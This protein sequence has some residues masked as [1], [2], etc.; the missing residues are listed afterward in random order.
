[1]R[2]LF[3]N[4]EEAELLYQTAK[5]AFKDKTK[6]KTYT[7]MCRL[8][9]QKPKTTTS[10]KEKHFKQWKTAF[11]FK[12]N[13]NGFYGIKVLSEAEH[14][15]KILDLILADNKYYTLCL[16][17]DAYKSFTN[18]PVL[19]ITNKKLN[20]LLGYVNQ[21][22]FDYYPNYDN[23]EAKTGMQKLEQDIVATGS[24]RYPEIKRAKIEIRE[25]RQKQ[26][27]KQLK[28]SDT[29]Q[30]IDDRESQKSYDRFLEMSKAYK[31]NDASK[32][33]P[34][35]NIRRGYKDF[36]DHTAPSLNYNINSL[37]Q[38]LERYGYIGLTPVYIGVILNENGTAEKFRLCD[39]EADKYVEL[40]N[41]VAN[42]T[43]FG[44]Y[45]RVV[46]SKNYGAFNEKFYPALKEE[47]G[48]DFIYKSNRIYISEEAF[49]SN[50]EEKENLFQKDINATNLKNMLQF[51][52]K[53]FREKM[54]KNNRNRTNNE[55]NRYLFKLM[56]MEFFE[57]DESLY[58]I[59]EKFVD[60]SNIL[61]P[62]VIEWKKAFQAEKVIED[63]SKTYSI[64][65]LEAQNQDEKFIE[66]DNS[67]LPANYSS[68]I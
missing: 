44:S 35:P 55:F 6:V 51:N 25:C 62:Q 28:I 11:N 61:I 13:E 17:L 16:L 49:Q 45:A 30:D 47:M 9:N 43:G 4:R 67:Y 53:E 15:R 29:L 46:V 10:S 12:Q 59:S 38:D 34:T 22:Y 3:K 21:S 18:S 65:S 8:L 31:D 52:A 64:T 68:L 27:S 48:Y 33:S 37:L 41:K 42:K 58:E 14:A 66:E 32:F 1:M 19:F 54:L 40:R 57:V 7:E 36:F 20:I 63:S 26:I 23:I 60:D 24:E 50:L 5:E 56:S 2:T 39:T